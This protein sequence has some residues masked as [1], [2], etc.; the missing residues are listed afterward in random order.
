[1]ALPRQSI[2]I[3]IFLSLKNTTKQNEN[4]SCDLNFPPF[5][6]SPSENS[7]SGGNKR[8][9]RE[10][11]EEMGKKYVFFFVFFFSFVWPS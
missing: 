3:Y 2:E 1:M 7:Y 6:S 4:N 11:E 8:S 9:S 5:P 10:E